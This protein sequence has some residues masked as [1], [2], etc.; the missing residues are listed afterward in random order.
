MFFLS[1]NSYCD[2]NETNT[3]TSRYNNW[4]FQ[5][6]NCIKMKLFA[7]HCQIISHLHLHLH[8]PHLHWIIFSFLFI[9]LLD[10]NQYNL[11]LFYTKSYFHLLPRLSFVH[12]IRIFSW[13]VQWWVKRVFNNWT[14]QWKW[15]KWE[16]EKF[17]A[18]IIFFLVHLFCFIPVFIKPCSMVYITSCYFGQLKW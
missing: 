10:S 14:I 5:V 8:Q 16:K 7:L 18:N 17:E 12:L 11:I 2:I 9:I 4:T 3:I 15:K 13:N 6:Q 1:N